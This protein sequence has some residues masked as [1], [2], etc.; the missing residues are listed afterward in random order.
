M[1][2]CCWHQQWGEADLTE[3]CCWC[4]ESRYSQLPRQT[5]IHGPHAT[6]EP[7]IGYEGERMCKADHTNGKRIPTLEDRVARLESMIEGGK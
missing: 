7:Y 3:K 4:G 5:S 2:Q 1:N 6:G